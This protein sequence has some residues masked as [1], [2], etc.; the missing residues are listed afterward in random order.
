MKKTRVFKPVRLERKPSSGKHA[1][2]GSIG[3]YEVHD[4]FVVTV[5]VDGVRPSGGGGGLIPRSTSESEL[6]AEAD[7]IRAFG[8]LAL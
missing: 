4:N 1:R 3:T 8:R 7:R 2:L 5:K 6:D